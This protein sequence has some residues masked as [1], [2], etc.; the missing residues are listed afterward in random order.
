MI[1]QPTLRPHGCLIDALGLDCPQ[2]RRDEVGFSA[3]GALRE[4]FPAECGSQAAWKTKRWSRAERDRIIAIV[5]SVARSVLEAASISRDSPATAAEPIEVCA[6]GFVRWRP[7]LRREPVS[8]ESGVYVF[9]HF[10][11]SPPHEVDVLDAAVLYI[12][13]TDRSLRHRLVEFENT[14]RG[15]SGHS[16][17]W[18]YRVE[19]AQNDFEAVTRFPGIFV[20]WIESS[21][22]LQL[23]GRMLEEYRQ[24]WRQWPRLNKKG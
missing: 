24:R 15:G 16:G 1:K 19:F 4:A 10:A 8:D 13:M 3:A 12:G 20:S 18:T 5:E 14:A 17:G 21:T 6:N 22:A 23:E 2:D 11:D 7:F 9:S